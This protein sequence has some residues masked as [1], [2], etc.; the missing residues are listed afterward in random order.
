L[1]P[2][3][4]IPSAFSPNGDGAND[5]FRVKTGDIPRSFNM[6]VFNR[7]GA[8]VFESADI[9]AGWNGTIGSN[10]APAGAYVYTVALITST[11]GVIKREGT[12]ILVR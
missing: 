3:Y 2:G 4:Y 7:Y 1:G 12:V 10:Q 8:K 5:I 9:S 11:G 6:I